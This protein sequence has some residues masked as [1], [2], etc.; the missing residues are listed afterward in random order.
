LKCFKGLGLYQPQTFD[1]K[2]NMTPYL[3]DLSARL[4][5]GTSKRGGIGGALEIGG[6][7]MAG[8]NAFVK[9]SFTKQKTI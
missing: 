1:A 9:S 4:L 5:G 2:E 7:A 8:A 3:L 6:Q